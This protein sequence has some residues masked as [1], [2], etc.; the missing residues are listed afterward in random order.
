MQYLQA[1]THSVLG[2]GE[3][4]PFTCRK[5]ELVLLIEPGSIS[6]EPVR[7]CLT[8]CNIE[9]VQLPPLGSPAHCSTAPSTANNTSHCSRFT[10]LPNRG[11]SGGGV[12]GG[13]AVHTHKNKKKHTHSLKTM[14]INTPSRI[15]LQWLNYLKMC[16][17][18]NNVYLNPHCSVSSIF[19]ECPQPKTHSR[20]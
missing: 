14:N 16:W 4:A 19:S 10:R 12:G 17:S 13:R 20:Y 3:T 9:S 6:P 15:Y 18:E 1:Q 11:Q 8:L 7:I 2:C 5:P